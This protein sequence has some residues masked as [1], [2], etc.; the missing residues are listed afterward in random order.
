M[1]INNHADKEHMDFTGSPKRWAMSTKHR[2]WLS[3]YSDHED[4]NKLPSSHSFFQPLR[5]YM[6]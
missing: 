6:Y 1:I 5:A 3:Y 2:H 4:Y